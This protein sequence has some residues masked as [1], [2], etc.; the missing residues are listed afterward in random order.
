MR[1]S[2]D[3]LTGA[4]REPR[5]HEVTIALAAAVLESAG[6][7]GDGRARGASRRST[8]ARRPSS[9][10]AMVAALGGPADLLEAP[11]LATA[12][13]TKAGDAGARRAT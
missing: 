2:I 10:A 8:P 7:A 9:F 5:L 3:Y 1:E 4:R 13:V 12:P 11:D 6:L